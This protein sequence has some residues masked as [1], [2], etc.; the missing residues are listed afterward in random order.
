MEVR[1]EGKYIGV[2][3]ESTVLNKYFVLV[4]SK[5]AGLIG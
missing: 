3:W 5:A 2:F 4:R 1:T